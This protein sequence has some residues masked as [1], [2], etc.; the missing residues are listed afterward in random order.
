M[1]K[2][3]VWCVAIAYAILAAGCAGRTGGA[4]GHSHDHDHAGHDHSAHN[5]DHS[6]H[7]HEGCGHDHGHDHDHDHGHSAAEGFEDEIILPAAQAARLGLEFEKAARG[8]FREAIR[9]SGDILAA[10]GDSHVVVAPVSGVVSFAQ[11]GLAPGT[12]VGRGQAM[13]RV[14]SRG[15]EGGDAAVRA[16]TEYETARS[17]YERAEKLIPEQIISQREYEEARAAYLDA[18]NR[19]E[20]L[21][22]GAG[23]A[24]SAVSAPVGGYVM[25]IG[26]AGGEYVEVG[27]RLA[28]VSQNARQRLVARVPQRHFASLPGIR[29][30]NVILPSGEAAA[31]AERGGRLVSA[32]RSIAPG[33]TM[34]PVTFEFDAHPDLAAGSTTTVFLLGSGREN[35]LTLPLA[36]VTESQ[37]AYFVFERIDDE[38]YLRR[39]VTLGAS[40]GQR[41][42]I[43][44]GLREGAEIVTRGAVHVKMATASAIPHS[45][46]H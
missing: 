10:Q 7:K 25:E 23:E 17:A 29:S 39:A 30:A 45:H 46:E 12:R 42:E 22:A 24:G 40:D 37:G 38:G 19:W 32:G 16:R 20:A 14:S 13:F 27:Q 34:I 15:I 8:P 6:E 31:L 1:K 36:A 44:S 35:V 21:S 28:V 2:T 4:N 26:A 18:R 9:V 43:V 3:I 41:V 33:E 11:A 5:H